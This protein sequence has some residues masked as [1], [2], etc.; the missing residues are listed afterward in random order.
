MRKLRIL[1]AF[2]LT[3]AAGGQSA[4]QAISKPLGPFEISPT[5]VISRSDRSLAKIVGLTVVIHDVDRPTELVVGAFTSLEPVAGGVR[6]RPSARSDSG[7]RQELVAPD[8]GEF[9][10]RTQSLN[11]DGL[12]VRVRLERGCQQV[13]EVYIRRSRMEGLIVTSVPPPEP[14]NLPSVT[15]A[16]AVLTTCAPWSERQPK[17]NP[18]PRRVRVDSFPRPRAATIPPI[19]AMLG[20]GFHNGLIIVTLT[21]ERTVA[22]RRATAHRQTAPPHDR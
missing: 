13:L 15:A 1:A 22:W 11:H 8:S 6:I 4:A 21:P 12:E 7:G 2:G 14:S 20:R 3:L 19:P 18:A 17:G 9:H 10:A 16:R 5:I